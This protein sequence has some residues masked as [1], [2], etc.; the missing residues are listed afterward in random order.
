MLGTDTKKQ[1][2]TRCSSFLIVPPAILIRLSLETKH[3]RLRCVCL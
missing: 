1:R 3:L 2:Y